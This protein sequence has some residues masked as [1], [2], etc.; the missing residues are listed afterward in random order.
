MYCE[1]PCKICFVSQTQ[2]RKWHIGG[3]LMQNSMNGMQQI[4]QCRQIVQHL[5]QQTQQSSQQYRQMLQQEQHNIQMLQQILAHEQQAAQ[6]IQLALN[7]HDAAIQQCQQVANMCNQL[8]QELTG[9]STVSHSFT[10]GQ[11]SMGQSTMGQTAIGGQAIH[12]VPSNLL[13]NQASSYTSNN[14]YQQ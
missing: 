13:H 7:G 2:S 11:A 8:Q 1:N 4:N 10:G 9:Q 6:T 14:M 3:I 12:S 5:I